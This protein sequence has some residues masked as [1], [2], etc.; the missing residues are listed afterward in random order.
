MM[1]NFQVITLTI[2]P[3][4]EKGIACNYSFSNVQ[5]IDAIKQNAAGGEL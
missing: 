2:P 5:V 3:C 1:N 4:S